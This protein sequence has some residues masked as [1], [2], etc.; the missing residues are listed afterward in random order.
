MT[1]KFDEIL[2]YWRGTRG[3]TSELRKFLN[4][5]PWHFDAMSHYSACKLDSG[6]TLDALAFAQTAVSTAYAAF[7]QDFIEGEHEIPGGFVEN[8][9]FLRCLYNLMITQYAMGE[10]SEASNTAYRM[11][12]YDSQDRMGARLE[13]P[14]YLLRL[15]MYSKVLALFEDE[16]FEDTFHA[17]KYLLPIA[18]LKVGRN[19]DA[20]RE[21][22]GCLSTP[23]IAKYLLNEGLPQPVP[24]QPFFGVTMGSELEGFL[25]ANEYRSFWQSEKDAL[26][27]LREYSVE[28]EAQGWPRYLRHD[29]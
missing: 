26:N 9:P 28:A 15:G 3:L 17:A 2:E 10:Y 4:K 7:P 11:L 1:L 20:R 14:K 25:Y 23:R 8:R 6:R 12:Q 16:Q 29:L 5:Y 13:L 19:D 21:I 24:E 22:R 27:L 18:L